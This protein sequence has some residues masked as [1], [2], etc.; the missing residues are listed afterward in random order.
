MEDLAKLFLV[1][2]QSLIPLLN[3]AIVLQTRI[4]LWLLAAAGVLFILGLAFL[5]LLKLKLKSQRN[6]PSTP[7][8]RLVLQRITIF[9]FWTSTAVMLGTAL[10][11]TQTASAMQFAT[12]SPSSEVHITSG[13]TLQGLQWTIFVLQFFF[14]LGIFFAVDQSPGRGPVSGGVFKT[15]GPSRSGVPERGGGGGP[16][17]IPGNF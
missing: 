17:A 7:R 4:F 15:V 10:S 1:N 6:N 16:F 11:I 3:L 8:T 9:T 5:T 14:S 2:E 12:S 13:I